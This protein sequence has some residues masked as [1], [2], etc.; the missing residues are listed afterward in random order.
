MPGLASR[1]SL[2]NRVITFETQ[3]KDGLTVK[4]LFVILMVMGFLAVTLSM[5]AVGCKDS[6][7]TSTPAAGTSTKG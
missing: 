5:G 1:L 7:S 2:N 4:K 6:K 3:G